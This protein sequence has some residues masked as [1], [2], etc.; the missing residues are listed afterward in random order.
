VAASVLD[1]RGL[2]IV[3]AG[4][5]APIVPG[6]DLSIVRGEAFALVGES[7]S[8]KT[9]TAL[10]LMGFAR[11]GTRIESGQVLLGG[12]DLFG[13]SPSELRR[14]R[15]GR[16][17]FVPQN[18]AASLNPSMRI[19]GQLR[20]MLEEHGEG[21][22]ADERITE[23]LRRVSLPDDRAFR[24]RYPHQLSGGQQQRVLIAMAL[25]CRP[26]LVVLDEPTTGLDVTTQAQVLDLIRELSQTH[27]MSLVYVTHD[28]AVV[29]GIADRVGV[30]YG[31][32][33]VEVGPKDEIF[34]AA[35]HP[36]T[37]KLLEAVPRLEG[38][39]RVLVGIPGSAP[40]PGE[41]GPGCTFTARC[42]YR[43]PRCDEPQAESEVGPGH[44]V[45]CVRWRELAPRLD[46]S[47]GELLASAPRAEPLLSVTD[48]TAVYRQR[49]GDVVA[50]DSV[51]LGL[52]RGETL[53]VVGESGS[54]KS[55]LARC[56]AGLHARWTGRIE[57]DGKQ[58]APRAPQRPRELRRRIQIV[59]QNPDRSLN[60]QHTVETIL[61]RPCRQLLDMSARDA[62]RRVHELLEQVRLPARYA[63]RYPLELSGGERQRV[64]V[65]RALA[66]RPDLVICDEVTSALDVSVQASLL[67]LLNQLRG[68]H[69]LALLFIS[70]DLAVVRAIADRIVVLRSGSV[71][72][73]RE[74]EELL[75]T[76]SDSYTRDLLAAAP[77]LP[78]PDIAAVAD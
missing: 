37:R 47:A 53:A 25:A 43:Q 32:A 61:A 69:S 70:H 45:R 29:A 55:T 7:G 31:G 75:S 76:P 14:L 24:R 48:L 40:G 22:E 52:M 46:I 19:D 38:E 5:G 17:S 78:E 68:E 27:E 50:L 72:E 9:S 66:A 10:A 11:P 59:F 35:R 39:R 28:L 3:V 71:R 63:V 34:G 23:L 73:D 12:V 30:M 60:P 36:Y 51:S 77:R 54:G 4:S 33:L 1:V 16:V 18:P 58:V 74:A 6:L 44:L 64:A 56:V 62:Q 13:L 21:A 49:G 67:E 42:P 8:G 41:Y 20:D 26:E 2:R 15:G 65:A 57:F